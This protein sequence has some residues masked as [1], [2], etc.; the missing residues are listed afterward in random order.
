[1]RWLASNRLMIRSAVFALLSFTSSSST[2]V[3]EPLKTV[4]RV[5]LH[6]YAG[7]WY[8]VA[9]LPNRFEKKCDRNVTAEYIV[10][11]NTVNVRNSCIKADGQPTSSSGKAKVVDTATNAKLKVTF[12]WPFYG[13]YWIIGLDR[14][15]R[16]AVVGE[17]DRKYMW[18]L[19]R[20]A[21]LSPE[22]SQQIDHVIAASGYQRSALIWTQ[23]KS[24]STR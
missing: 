21:S 19:S 16:W 7:K 10:D 3:P 1:M 2:L 22:D 11:G 24:E 23:Q 13:Q 18:V 12:F 4:D 20:T 9:R 14:D 5:D 8:E 15:Y 17:P 6:R